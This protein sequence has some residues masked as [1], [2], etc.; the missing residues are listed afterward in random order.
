MGHDLVLPQPLMI[1]VHKHN[2]NASRCVGWALWRHK[3]HG[4]PSTS[5]QVYSKLCA[6]QNKRTPLP[7]EP[8]YTFELLKHDPIHRSNHATIEA[9]TRILHDAFGR[10]VNTQVKVWIYRYHS[11]CTHHFSPCQVPYTWMMVLI[12]CAA[13]A[14]QPRP[15]TMMRSMMDTTTVGFVWQCC[16]RGPLLC[17]WPLC[18][19]MEC[20]AQAQ[21]YIPVADAVYTC[22]ASCCSTVLSDAT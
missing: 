20:C 8:G 3:V 19:R 22:N 14:L 17:L 7:S 16:V 15:L 13:F 12:S 1:T 9:V 18:G 6:L 10:G 11:L 21:L 2:R 4:D 5:P